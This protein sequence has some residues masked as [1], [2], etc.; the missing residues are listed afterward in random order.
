GLRHDGCR[1]VPAS[2]DARQGLGSLTAAQV[3]LRSMGSMK[4]LCCFALVA[5]AAFA[6]GDKG[7]ITGS[8]LNPVGASVDRATVQARNSET[9]TAYKATSQSTGKYTL[10]DLPPGSYDISVFVPG[11]KPFQKKG[12]QVAAAKISPADIHLEEGT[13]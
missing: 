8:V 10:A 5:S 3:I 1:G 9:G 7:A 2:R 11:L 4:L 13:Q 12:V 6:D